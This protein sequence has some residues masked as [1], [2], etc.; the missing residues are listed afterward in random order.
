MIVSRPNLSEIEPSVREYIEFLEAELARLRALQFAQKERKIRQKPSNAQKSSEIEIP[1]PPLEVEEAPTTINVIS[2]TGSGLAKRTLRH[3]YNRQRRGG[4]GI[5]DLDCPKEDP[6]QVLLTVEPDRHIL[7]FTNLARAFRL[8]VKQIPEGPV[9]SKGK[10]IL[11]KWQLQEGEHFVA[12]LPDEASGAIAL[13]SQDGFIRYLRHHVFGEYMKPGTVLFDAHKFGQLAGICR[14][15]GNADLLIVSHHGKGIRFAEKLVPPQGGAGM[16]LDASD[17]AVA[18]A[19]VDDDS[20]VFLTDEQGRGTVRLMS[21]FTANKSAGGSGKI[22]MNSKSLMAAQAI[23]SSEDI[24]MI[25]RLS[26][27]I[28]FMSDEVP[29]KDSNVQGV[30]CMTLRGDDVIAITTTGLGN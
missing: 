3:L 25:S 15:L 12:A 24:L 9:R 27:L 4:M 10:S 8:P 17:R 30:N 11:G 29:P 6:V 5:F 26:K 23:K 7:L 22:V 13:V 19:S 18:V 2:L 14:T 16:R 20:K 21:N 1:L 28:R